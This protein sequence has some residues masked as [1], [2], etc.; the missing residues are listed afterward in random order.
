MP[1]PLQVSRKDADPGS[2]RHL[3]VYGGGGFFGRLVVRDLLQHTLA[4]ITIASR[5]PRR[6]DFGAHESRVQWTRSNFLDADSVRSVIRGADA[7]ISCAGPYQGMSLDLLEACI[8]HGV[9]YI[10]V[11]DDRDFVERAYRLGPRIEQA[12]IFAFV[13]CSVV[14]GM[15]ALLARFASE[16]VGGCDRV[17]I[18]ISPGTKDARGP[19]SFASLLSTVGEEFTVPRDGSRKILRGWTERERADFPAP[20]GRRWVYSVMDVADHLTLPQNLGARSVSFKIGSEMDILNRAMEMVR[21]IKSGL[22]P[23]MTNRL[24]PLMRRAIGFLGMFGTSRGAMMVEVTGPE[25]QRMAL[26]VSRESEGQIIPAILPSLAAGTVLEG[27]LRTSGIVPLHT[28]VSEER[29]RGELMRR[30]CSLSYRTEPSSPWRIG[31]PG[32][33]PSGEGLELS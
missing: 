8:K 29:L 32:A 21:W 1:L 7:I 18:I 19:A 23:R 6:L 17:R 30:G 12:G 11:A 13:G 20:V 2:G 16:R 24:I 14:P 3:V 9:H 26:S 4:R 31:P 33:S 10:D 27:E 22:G 28:W 15:S 5:N 25:G